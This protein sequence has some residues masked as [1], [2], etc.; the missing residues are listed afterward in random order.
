MKSMCSININ[1]YRKSSFLMQMSPMN[2]RM[3]LNI[4]TPCRYV[5]FDVFFFFLNL[6]LNEIHPCYGV[7][8]HIGMY[9]IDEVIK[10]SKLKPCKQ[11]VEY[12]PTSDHIKIHE[13]KTIHWKVIIVENG[14][15][16]SIWAQSRRI[17]MLLIRYRS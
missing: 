13:K 9:T 4:K 5:S 7:S 14:G 8:N 11:T 15:K 1:I 12:W 16:N 17:R 6:R 3:L 2:E 10:R